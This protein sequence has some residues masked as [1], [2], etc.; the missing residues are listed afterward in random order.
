MG[1]VRDLIEGE[2]GASMAE[3]AS[4]TGR[5]GWRFGLGI[6]CFVAAFAIHLVTLA[7]VAMGAS[8]ATVGAI[9]AINFVLNK[10]LLLA[11]AAI[12]GTD[13]FNRLKGLVT[14]AVKRH[15]LPDEVG[16]VRYGIGLILFVAPLIGAWV[17][18]YVAELAPSLGRNTVRDGV[19]ADAVLI[20][21]LFVLGGGFW[22]KL[23]ALFVRHATVLFPAKAPRA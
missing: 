19:I 9:G 22:D 14:G 8:A 23:R 10:V 2:V 15:V 7:A 20:V 3:S 5:G 6:A 4:N 16:P 17:S 21:S 18:P 12:L 13:G 11:T 1:P